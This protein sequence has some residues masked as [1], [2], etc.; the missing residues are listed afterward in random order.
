MVTIPSPRHEIT[1]KA[2]AAFLYSGWSRMNSVA[3][4]MPSGR[5]ATTRISATIMN[6]RVPLEDVLL[7][8]VE[9]D[10]GLAARALNM[11]IRKNAGTEIPITAETMSLV[12]I[13]FLVSS[14]SLR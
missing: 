14:A 6:V 4:E 13:R 9:S 12:L 2:I 3:K 5:K 8:E 1:I 7:C 10:S 11:A